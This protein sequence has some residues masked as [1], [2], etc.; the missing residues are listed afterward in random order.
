MRRIAL[1]A[2]LLGG[3]GATVLPACLTWT[4]PVPSDDDASADDDSAPADDDDDTEP[5]DDDDGSPPDD[6]DDDDSVVPVDLAAAGVASILRIDGMGTGGVPLFGLALFSESVQSP[7]AEEAALEEVIGF[8]L[9]LF[10]DPI[11]PRIFEP[12]GDRYAGPWTTVGE[13]LLVEL[14]SAVSGMWPADSGAGYQW[15]PDSAADAALVAGQAWTFQVPEGTPWAGAWAGPALPDAPEPRG[16]ALQGSRVYLEAGGTLDLQASAPTP[17]GATDVLVALGYVLGAARGGP[18]GGAAAAFYV[19]PASG[20]ISLSREA[21]DEALSGATFATLYWIRTARQAQQTPGGPLLLT[22]GQWSVFDLHLLLAGDYLVDVQPETAPT[23]G[24]A[25]LVLSSAAAPWASDQEIVVTVGGW[26]ASSVVFDGPGQLTVTMDL[27]PLA[28]GSAEVVVSGAP[29][30]IGFG[31]LQVEFSP[32]ACDFDETED[33]DDLSQAEPI[34]IGQVACGAL[35]PAG[36]ADFFS[37][38]ATAGVSYRMTVV[39]QRLGYPTD[40]TLTLLDSAGNPLAFVDDFFGYDPQLDFVAGSSG[41][42]GLRVGPYDDAVGGPDFGYRLST[43]V[44]P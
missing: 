9:P 20:A 15:L 2:G 28:P 32:P 18:S 37:F 35:D 40:P 25:T 5:A 30:G 7:S 27:S 8:P 39:A 1:P 24:S 12:F 43:G 21:L 10:A 26:Q 14:G 44:L 38:T 31:V 23:P 33:N 29:S 4:P 17:E 22:S 11:S 13:P 36:D 34:A 3:L 41:T 42:Y 16:A 19:D 6:D